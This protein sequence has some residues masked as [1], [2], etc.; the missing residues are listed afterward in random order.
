MGLLVLILVMA[1]NYGAV[2]LLLYVLGWAEDSRFEATNVI[3]IFV[4]P[5]VILFASHVTGLNL[6]GGSRGHVEYCGSGRYQWE[7]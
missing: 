5:F 2:W 1:L 3:C 4:M 7:C 6:T